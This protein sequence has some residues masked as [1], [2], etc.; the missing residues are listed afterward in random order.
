MGGDA[1]QLLAVNN[2]PGTH[3]AFFGTNN[4]KMKAKEPIQ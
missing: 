4:G 1:R 2:E 3:P